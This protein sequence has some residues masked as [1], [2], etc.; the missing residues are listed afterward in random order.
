MIYMGMIV[1]QH[2]SF[3][4]IEYYVTI[5]AQWEKNA[6]IVCP[7]LRKGHLFHYNSFAGIGFLIVPP[8]FFFYK[9]LATGTKWQW[10]FGFQER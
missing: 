6:R 3:H 7:N 8:A 4:Y 2:I 5:P 9:A 1:I 10:T